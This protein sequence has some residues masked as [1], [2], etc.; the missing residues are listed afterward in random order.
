MDA[1]I[2]DI[3]FSLFQTSLLGFSSNLF[4]PNFSFVADIFL[5]Q[6]SGSSRVQ[7]EILTGKL[8]W[9]WVQN[10]RSVIALR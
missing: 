2:S 8:V 9:D 4:W 5:Y 10:S 7:H 6:Y 1:P 3:N